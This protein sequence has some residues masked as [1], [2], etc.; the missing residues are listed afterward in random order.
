MIVYILLDL[1]LSIVVLHVQ[2]YNTAVVIDLAR[3]IEESFSIGF[4]HGDM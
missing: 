4:N 1:D 3:S 2:L